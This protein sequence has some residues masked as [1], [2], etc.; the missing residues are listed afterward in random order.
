MLATAAAIGRKER[1]QA[2]RI[3]SG[4]TLRTQTAFDD[5]LAR[6]KRHPESAFRQ[7]LREIGGAIEE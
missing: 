3:R 2:R 7:H 4:V 1:D 5:Y 6:R